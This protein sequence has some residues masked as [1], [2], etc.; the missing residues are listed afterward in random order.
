MEVRIE[1]VKLV[2]AI[3]LQK[4][5][6]FERKPRGFLPSLPFRSSPHCWFLTLSGNS[7]PAGPGWGA[8]RG[9]TDVEFVNL[10]KELHIRKTPTGNFTGKIFPIGALALKTV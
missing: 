5:L 8:L 3:M 10:N 4:I 7:S 6:L 1:R 9:D 2:C